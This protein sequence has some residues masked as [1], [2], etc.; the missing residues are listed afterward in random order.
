MHEGSHKN[1]EVMFPLSLT[2]SRL[3]NLKEK[4]FPWKGFSGAFQTIQDLRMAA[5]KTK[6]N[7][8][9]KPRE[10]KH[11]HKSL[12]VKVIVVLKGFKTERW[13]VF[14]HIIPSRHFV[15]DY[16]KKR[17]GWTH[18]R[19]IPMDTFICRFIFNYRRENKF[20]TFRI[21]NNVD[22]YINFHLPSLA[23]GAYLW[24]VSS[25]QFQWGARVFV[26]LCYRY[27]AHPKPFPP[28]I[29]LNKIRKAL[30]LMMWGLYAS[31]SLPYISV[32]LLTNA[33]TL[34]LRGPR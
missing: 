23:Y 16:G 8:K 3:C 19:R 21:K 11:G 2:V 15:S 29:I 5:K 25:V 30:N 27:Y 17:V 7:Q 4:Y 20:C 14:L 10:Q 28:P 13:V 34:L 22:C 31:A 24:T 32:P 1:Y 9:P 33:T 26:M 18:V 6:P 12:R